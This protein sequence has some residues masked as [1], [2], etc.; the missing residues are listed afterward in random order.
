MGS[1]KVGQVG[2]KAIEYLKK[3]PKASILS[4]ATKLHQDHP[5]LFRNIQAGR[6]AIGWHLNL[7]KTRDRKYSPS[8][9]IK[10]TTPFSK[11]NPYGLP[12]S[13]ALPRVPFILPKI[14]N[15]ILVLSDLHFPYQDNG[16]I[17]RAIRYGLEHKVNT[18]FIN[19][20]LLDCFQL[21]KFEKNPDNRPT[22]KEEIEL[23]K[24]FLTKLRKLFPTA[25]IYYHLGNHDVRY[26]RFMTSHSIMLKDLFGDDETSLESR[27]N[28]INL[29]IHMIGD[30]QITYCGT[31]GLLFH[32]GHYIFRGVQS[33]VSPAKTIYDKMGLSMI[34]GHTHKISEFTKIDGYGNIHTCWSTGSLAELL[35]DYA[36]M[37]NNYAHGFA[38]AIIH[39]DNT[40]TV[41]NYRL[42]NG[43]IL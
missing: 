1:K 35:P 25:Q 41:R 11:Q 15:N 32:H 42:S 4:L 20:D 29:R 43:K 21:S 2:L 26:E 22:T 3:Y 8:V 36:P 39:L 13:Y 23:A 28:L 34:C 7:Y 30:K 10:H 27:L 37:A 19:G 33:P 24:D 6:N 17:T 9:T 5:A 40:F 16:S 12:P 18:I 31:S 14:N 38:H